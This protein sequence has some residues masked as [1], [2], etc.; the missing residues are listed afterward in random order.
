MIGLAISPE[1]E[2]R[3][4][5]FGDEQEFVYEACVEEVA[6]SGE[7]DELTIFFGSSD[8][9][10]KF[11]LVVELSDHD[12]FREASEDHEVPPAIETEHVD[13]QTIINVLRM[14]SAQIL[15]IAVE[16]ETGPDPSS[17]PI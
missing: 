13:P 14:P 2:L 4:L 7:I 9:R 8:G 11:G 3:P 16:M 12:G 15:A 17:L 1:N 10:K 5:F 6:P